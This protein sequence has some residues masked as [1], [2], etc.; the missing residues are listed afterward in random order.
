MSMIYSDH[1]VGPASCA[2]Y[3]EDVSYDGYIF[4]VWISMDV[5][6]KN[7]VAL[8]LIPSSKRK[9]MSDSL[10]FT[11]F[12]FGFLVAFSVFGQFIDRFNPLDRFYF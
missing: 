8:R 9:Q 12:I 4:S 5:K 3:L 7:E 1:V 10:I 6:K 2:R 11:T